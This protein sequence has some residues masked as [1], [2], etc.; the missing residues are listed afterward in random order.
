MLNNT[1][2]L[3]TTFIFLNSF[4]SLMVIKE[5]YSP[6]QVMKLTL[7]VSNDF[8]RMRIFPVTFK[9]IEKNLQLFVLGEVSAILWLMF[10]LSIAVVASPRVPLV[11]IYKLN[12]LNK[13]YKLNKVLKMFPNR[14]Q[15]C[16]IQY[17]PG[18]NYF[19]VL[20]VVGTT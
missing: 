7:L 1:P 4:S 13:L 12:L 11:S 20:S 2:L 18:V 3:K 19:V 9:C 14:M 17:C 16:L 6:W 10:S 15:R 5:V 8:H